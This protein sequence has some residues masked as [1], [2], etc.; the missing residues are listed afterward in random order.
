MA[1]VIVKKKRFLNRLIKV[2]TYL[3]NEWGHNVAVVF[4]E[5]TDQKIEMIR[6]YPYIG[7]PS[8]IRDTRSLLVT[9]HNRLFCRI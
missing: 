5:R 4:L 6:T 1:Y 8:G 3:D 9:K 7:I 2:L